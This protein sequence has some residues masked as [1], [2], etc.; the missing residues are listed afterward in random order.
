MAVT[1]HWP[2]DGP[3]KDGQDPHN[4]YG[5]WQVYP[6]GQFEHHLLPFQAAFAA[7]TGG[8]MGSYAIPVGFDTVGINFSKVMIADLLREEARLRRR[9]RHRL[10][11]QH[12]VG[13]RATRREGAAAPH[14]R[15]RVWTRSAETT[16]RA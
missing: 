14:R 13:R 7:G 5:R 1:K 4:D 9:R 12:A 10:A 3:V 6:G 2:G 16:T 15:S 11:A 8:I